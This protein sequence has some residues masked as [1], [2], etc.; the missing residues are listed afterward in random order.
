[1]RY[2]TTRPHDETCSIAMHGPACR[3]RP[4]T[5]H[6]RSRRHRP[7]HALVV[8]LVLTGG[9]ARAAGAQAGSIG[10]LEGTVT[11]S[12]HAR[13]L[14]DVRVL[15]VDAASPGGV[16][17][18]ATTDAR[19]AF[20]I[21][22]LP[23][24]RYLV[25][26]ESALLDSL[27]VTLSP[28]QVTVAS[29]T[30]AT[31]DLAIPPAPKLRAAV[32]PGVDLPAGTGII[33]GQV[34]SAE[35]AGPLPD[36]VL[37]M[38]WRELSFDRKTARPSNEERSASVTTDAGGWYRVC[39]V[40]TGAF[41]SM[42]LQKDGRIG[43][44]IPTLVDD[45]LGI[46]IR[47]LSFSSGPAQPLAAA[48]GSERADSAERSGTALLSGVI[49][50]P[51]DAPVEN[52][53]VRVRGAVGATRTDAS[54]RYSLAGLPAGTQV[55]EVRRFGYEVT[56]LP[57]ELRSG[58]VTARD[59]RLRRLVVTLDSM[60]VVATRTRYPQYAEH[61]KF[62]IGGLFLGPEQLMRERASFTSDIFA[63]LPGF[64][65]DR[66]RGRGVVLSTRYGAQCRVNVVIDGLNVLTSDRD[67][68]SVDDVR[69]GDIGAI[70][71]YR[72]GEMA[73]ETYDRGCGAI[74]IW[75][76]R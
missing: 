4:S 18:T 56:E 19:G 68:I 62:A 57:I 17:H 70:E 75:T 71:A 76:K 34:V 21:D 48:G 29:G 7:I 33:Y 31:A 8:A 47:R 60:R 32:C 38:R 24:G 14:G 44:V 20:R 10:S 9:L 13:P 65:V 1:M 35:T 40:P 28:R 66:T 11:D 26:F 64:Q 22:S 69:P 30:A 27:V 58:V 15:A 72:A 3:D 6:T 39:G 37:A 45:T 54:G 41:V 61:R 23:S 49:R 42:Q 50:D 16:P 46:A 5:G 63:K 53:E 52:A 36:V 12:V 67:A 74:V 73:P 59:V 55:L 51:A 43:P 25:G 2:L